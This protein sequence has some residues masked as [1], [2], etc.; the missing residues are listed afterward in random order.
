MW[1]DRLCYR[2]FSVSC[3]SFISWQFNLAEERLSQN[4]GADCHSMNLHNGNV[5]K[6][7][8]LYYTSWLFCF[9]FLLEIR[10]ISFVRA[11]GKEWLKL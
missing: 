2:F 4:I 3:L 8:H 6:A 10:L 11:V 9:D 7:V 1:K 5:K